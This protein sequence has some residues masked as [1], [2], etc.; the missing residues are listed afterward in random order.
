MRLLTQSAEP[1][2]EILGV[3]TIAAVADK[4]Y[5]KIEDIEACEK[6]GI[7]PYVLRP[8]RDPSF[9]ADVFRK[10]EFRYDAASDSYVCP[11]GQC[12][13]PCSPSLLGGLKKVRVEFN[14]TALAY[15]LRRVLNILHTQSSRRLCDRHS[16]A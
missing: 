13:H 16:G 4:G 11:A 7:V 10:D 1:A 15:N 8:Q 12:L 2:K 3:E 5:F 9:R 6:A 14:L